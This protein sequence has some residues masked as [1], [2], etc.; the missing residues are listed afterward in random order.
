MLSLPNKKPVACANALIWKTNLWKSWGTVTV[1]L[2]DALTLSNLFSRPPFDDEKIS[3][4]RDLSL[5][6]VLAEA[7]ALLKE[8]GENA[9]G[10][11]LF[12]LVKFPAQRFVENPPAN[13]TSP[14]PTFSKY[15]WSWMLQLPWI[16][17]LKRVMNFS[18]S[19]PDL[20]CSVAEAFSI[21][22]FRDEGPWSC[23]S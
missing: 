5:S 7:D 4:R 16:L 18:P 1:V 13:V 21:I 12:C 10:T 2:A 6:P 22:L 3:R 17:L 23:L 8:K 9:P 20:S 14:I 19:F 15:W 11:D